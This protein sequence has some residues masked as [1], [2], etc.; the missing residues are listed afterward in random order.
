[1][2]GWA[3][4]AE[5]EQNRRGRQTDGRRAGRVGFAIY[6]QAAGRGD[7]QHETTGRQKGGRAERRREASRVP[8]TGQAEMIALIIRQTVLDALSLESRMF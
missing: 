6:N 4:V 3:T 1:M 7:I 2:D 5:T 8:P